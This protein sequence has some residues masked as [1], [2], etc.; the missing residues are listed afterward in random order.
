MCVSRVFAVIVSL[1]A[2]ALG[3]CAVNTALADDST[4][5][6]GQT[7]LVALASGDQ[8][9]EQRSLT[10]AA[11]LS[12]RTGEPVSGVPVTF[13]VLTTV[14]GE[15]LMRVG[16]VL[17]DSTGSAS[18]VY[19]PTWVGDH[20]VVVRFNG[21]DDLL[22]AQTSFRAN[23]IGPAHV[24]ENAAFGLEPVRRWLPFAIG[25]VVLAVWATL[26]FVMFRTLVGM[27]GEAAIAEP[28][29]T[30]GWEPL[31]S[32]Q[33]GR[34]VLVAAAVVVLAV[35]MTWLLIG[36]GGEEEPGLSSGSLGVA[37]AERPGLREPAAQ[38]AFP[39][40]LVRSVPTLITDSR[41][42]ISPASAE[43]PADAAVIDG[44]EFILDANKGRILAV[45]GDGELAPIVERERSG[46]VS[47]LGAA[48]MTTHD[49]KLYVANYVPGNVVVV[50]PTG[51]IE[52]V[53]RPELPQ[54]QP[55]LIPVGI[56]VGEQGEIYL[57]DADNHRV[58][59]LNAQG[60]FLGVVGEDD[61]SSRE[62]G[63]HTPGGLALDEQNNL[64]IVDT[65]S[66]SVK[67]YSR[68]GSLIMSIGRGRLVEPREVAV[69]AAGNTFVSD[70][71]L[72]SGG[73]DAGSW[74]QAPRGIKIEGNLLYVMDRL[75]GLL[76]FQLG[77]D[78]GV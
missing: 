26:G 57:S 54:G 22:P 68:T 24:H 74:L 2:M 77:G 30:P 58:V 18:L 14:F 40:P 10:L 73:E 62:N 38:K 7:T 5:R 36:D 76:V 42:Q 50:A 72:H 43:L 8:G 21:N 69:D 47:L 49:R 71:G 17:T 59:I 27:R 60:E 64:H 11:R 75:A 46:G 78:D 39:A 45:T 4:E 28:V 41:G 15:R 37:G 34:T 33:L 13:Y 70:D 12:G 23:A 3:V 19:E 67:Q 61:P 63:F 29:R 56:A 35:S 31:V 9:P 44:R 55:P 6:A 20:T 32:W 48:A 16:D 53:I 66:H 1:A 52:E 51:K 25:I 65:S